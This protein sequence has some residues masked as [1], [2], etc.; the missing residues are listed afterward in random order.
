MWCCFEHGDELSGFNKSGEI[1]DKNIDYKF[2][3]KVLSFL[4]VRCLFALH[5]INSACPCLR[6]I[7]IS[8]LRNKAFHW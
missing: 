2:L 7:H 8:L 1:V 3:K 5:I 6:I 4:R